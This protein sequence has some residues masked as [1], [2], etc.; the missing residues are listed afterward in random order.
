MLLLG[1]A[2]ERNFNGFHD[3]AKSA[4]VGDACISKQLSVIS[5]DSMIVQSRLR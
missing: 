4:E 2:A 3:C 5:M 1:K